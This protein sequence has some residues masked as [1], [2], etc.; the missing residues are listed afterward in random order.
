MLVPG[1]KKWSYGCGMCTFILICL[2][3][4]SYY[5]YHVNLSEARGLDDPPAVE[6]EV[7]REGTTY[8][9]SYSRSK[10]VLQHCIPHLMHVSHDASFLR[11]ME[12]KKQAL[13]NE[14]SFT[15]GEWKQ[16]SG[17]KSLLPF[18]PT[19]MNTSNGQAED[20]G[21]Q[22]ISF[23]VTDVNLPS[24]YSLQGNMVN[25]SAVLQVGC[26][27]TIVDK[28]T[29]EQDFLVQRGLTSLKIRMEGVYAE[30]ETEER[31]FCMLGSSRLPLRGKNAS[32]PWDWLNS[33]S[34]GRSTFSPTLIDDLKLKAVVYFPRDLTLMSCRVYK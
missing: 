9:S 11:E 5:T 4:L 34:I 13:T 31:V 3:Y 15:Y 26:I 6:I 22:F 17:Q 1:C 18:I 12:N 21:F 10:E 19:F 7:E 16:A 27:S 8:R 24:G 30:L 14:L 32:Q 29:E 28:S 25:V 2:A 20:Q 23:R 33:M